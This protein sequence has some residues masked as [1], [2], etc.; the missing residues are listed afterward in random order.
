MKVTFLKDHQSVYSG[1]EFYAAGAKA[2]LS[3]GQW[4]IDS[5]VAYEGWGANSPWGQQQAEPTIIEMP[6]IVPEDE[7]VLAVDLEGLGVKELR[8]RAKEAGIVGFSRMKK[9]QLI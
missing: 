1:N 8:K 3:G 5:G 4:L 6:V 7:P 9:A 2:D